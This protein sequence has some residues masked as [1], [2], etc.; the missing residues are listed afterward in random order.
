MYVILDNPHF[1]VTERKNSLKV[2]ELSKRGV[3]DVILILFFISRLEGL[4]AQCS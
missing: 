1:E 2:L 4:A 3:C